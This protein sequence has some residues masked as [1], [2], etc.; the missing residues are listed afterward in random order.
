MTSYVTFSGSHECSAASPGPGERAVRPR[1]VLPHRTARHGIHRGRARSARPPRDA[2][3]SALQPIARRADPRGAPDLVGI[4]AMH[5]LETDEV[6]A[7][8]HRVRALSPGVPVVVG[9][10]T[11]AAYPEP[12]LVAGHRRGRG[13]RRRTRAA[14]VCDALARGEPLTTRAG[15][16]AARRR[17]RRRPHGRRDRHAGRSTSAAARTASRRRVAPAVRLPGASPGV[18]GR[19]RARLPVPLLL[20]LDLAAARALGAR[21]IDRRRLPRLRGGRR[22]RVRRRRS[23]LAP[24]VAQPR[25]GAR[26][27]AARRPQAVDSGAEPRPIW[28]RG[29]AELLDA[30]RPLAKDFDI[31]FGLEAATDEGLD[32]L[33]EGR[34]RRRERPRRRGRARAPATA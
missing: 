28:S 12:F 15:A 16:G 11:A 32:E 4:A 25:A 21:A 20:L 19:D 23:V 31:F 7:L 8:A 2:R 34:D 30:W 18:A 9:G 3:R 22:S 24:P 14:A 26:A 5:A 1:S 6:I 13:R 33:A 10:H 29:I 17:R 27:A